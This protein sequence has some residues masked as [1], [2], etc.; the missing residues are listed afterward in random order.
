MT[1]PRRTREISK[2]R[3][4]RYFLYTPL[5]GGSGT[6]ILPGVE[7]FYVDYLMHM[8]TS[9]GNRFVFAER[10]RYGLA[11]PSGVPDHG[12]TLLRWFS[13]EKDVD[14]SGCENQQ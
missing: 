4:T 10:I 1:Y 3:P 12:S 5:A 13:T 6:A 7:T 11:F 9:E 8:P 2:Y 14:V